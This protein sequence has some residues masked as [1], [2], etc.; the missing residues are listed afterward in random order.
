MIENAVFAVDSVYCRALIRC[1]I[2]LPVGTLPITVPLPAPK[3]VGKFGEPW[4]SSV[5]THF[6]Q[7]GVG[8][9]CFGKRTFGVLFLFWG[10]LFLFL[11]FFFNLLK[12]GGHINW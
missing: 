9:R 10:G 12:T 1:V 2:I 5:S 11:F 4:G 8:C 6:P 7:A 3:K